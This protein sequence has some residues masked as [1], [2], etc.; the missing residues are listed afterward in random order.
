MYKQ[1]VASDQRTVSV[2]EGPSGKPFE[3]QNEELRFSKQYI[4]K[5][6]KNHQG[7]FKS[8]TLHNSE[9]FVN[10]GQTPASTKSRDIPHNH[11][12]EQVAFKASRNKGVCMEKA[13]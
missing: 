4:N 12:S 9:P 7:M 2:Y 6:M 13:L 11:T 8:P 10:L 3:N 5:I 1:P